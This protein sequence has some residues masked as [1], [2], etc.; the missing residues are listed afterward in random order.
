MKNL[1]I[2][3]KLFIL[4]KYFQNIHQNTH[5]QNHD[6]LLHYYYVIVIFFRMA[7]YTLATL[8]RNMSINIVPCQYFSR[9][10]VFV[11]VNYL[12]VLL[13]FQFFLFPIP[14]F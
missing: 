11:S 10:F 9:T 6:V 8:K 14:F 1:I 12:I 3:K 4:I 13:D 2:L 5:T 7:Y